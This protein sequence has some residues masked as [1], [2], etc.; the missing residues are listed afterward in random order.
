MNNDSKKSSVVDPNATY[1]SG[2]AARLSGVPV[3]TLRV[4]ERRYSVTDPNRSERGQRQYSFEDVR[5][6]GLIKQLVDAGNSIGAVAHLDLQQL[7]AM[8]GA[9]ANLPAAQSQTQ[10]NNG[11]LRIALVGV[12]L[13]QS[14]INLDP[15][16]SKLSLVQTALNL[17]QAELQL[18][19][20]RV[21][22]VVVEQGEL[23]APEE[24]IPLLKAAQQACQANAVLILYR[25]ASS[26]AIRQMRLAGFHVARIPSDMLE[27]DHL[28][29]V[30]L[31]RALTMAEQQSRH[32]RNKKVNVKVQ[33]S[34]RN[35]RRG[36]IP[37]RLIDDE[38]LM[39]IARSATSIH[40]ECPRHL[41]DLL[42]MLTSFER[43][44]AQ[45]E[46]RNEDDASLHRDL[47]HTAA[48]ARSA[49]EQA[50]VRV[51]QAEGIQY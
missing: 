21:D 45:C 50:L 32:G 29:R 10:V 23:T 22:V 7:L 37:A 14:L 5:R 4:W 39:H 47:H 3:E 27:V 6:L 44:S 38:S 11:L 31:A 48:H 9:V 51:A 19:D 2:A 16:M 26:D 40:C 42:Q 12:M 36:G 18:K 34:A 33:E 1:R 46:N 13:R 41:V 20:V 8:L 35:N 43:Y 25:F 49:L 28:C 15:E 17:K 24:Q 30:A